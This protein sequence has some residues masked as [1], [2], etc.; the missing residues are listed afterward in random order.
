MKRIL[1][2]A[3]ALACLL[4]LVGCNNKSMNYIIENK[5]SVTGIVEEVH[6]DYVIMYSETA[7]GY[8]NGS[9][10]HIPLDVENQ[11]SYTDVV[12]GDEIVVYYDGSAMETD[13][14]QI[15]TVYAITLKTPADRTENKDKLIYGDTHGPN[16][17]NSEYAVNGDGLSLDTAEFD[18][19]VSYANYAE[20]TGGLNA[21][22][23]AISSVRHLPIW[24]FDTIE[25]LE[26]FKKTNDQFT[27]DG[28]Y[29]EVSS[30]NDTVAKYDEVFFESNSLMLVYVSVNSGSYRYGVN[31]VFCDGVSFC[32]HVE[33]LNYPEAVTEDMAGWFITVAVSD[34]MVM[35]CTEFDAD[36]NNIEN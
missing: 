14:L 10:W 3:L 21:D 28:G 5:P 8:P 32:I 1:A 13:P 7:E 24:K 19:T 34:S 29:D 35:N 4:T 27:Y 6:D 20:I 23:M 11:D 15:A 30:F 2:M 36:L 17:D 9:H 33:Q 31:S 16:A 26:Q 12:V 22:K 18:I 25:E